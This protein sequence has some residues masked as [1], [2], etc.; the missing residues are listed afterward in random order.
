[1]LLQLDIFTSVRWRIVICLETGASFTIL[2]VRVVDTSRPMVRQ[3]WR[4]GPK[5][6]KKPRSEPPTITFSFSRSTS[7]LLRAVRPVCPLLKT[8]V[9]KEL[10]AVRWW[11]LLLYGARR[12][13][14]PSGALSPAIDWCAVSRVRDTRARPVVVRLPTKGHQQPRDSTT[15][16]VCTYYR[17]LSPPDKRAT[18]FAFFFSLSLFFCGSRG[19]DLCVFACC[20]LEHG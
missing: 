6:C 11:R 8:Q 16:S 17:H 19:N 7:D 2:L 18:F 13:A 4:L 12:T 5:R 1:M 10:V 9:Y 20:Q 3:G 14:G 15:G